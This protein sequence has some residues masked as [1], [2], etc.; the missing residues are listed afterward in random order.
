[1]AGRGERHT[2]RARKEEN[3][4]IA[5]PGLDPGIDPAIHVFPLRLTLTVSTRRRRVD[6]PDKPG[7]DGEKENARSAAA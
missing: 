2:R 4:V 6:G 1:M 3:I 5:V 7:H